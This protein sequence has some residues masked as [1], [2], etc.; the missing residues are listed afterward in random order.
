MDDQKADKIIE[1]ITQQNKMIGRIGLLLTHILTWM[2]V[3]FVTNFLVQIIF[4]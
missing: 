2:I 1:L 4:R 3:L